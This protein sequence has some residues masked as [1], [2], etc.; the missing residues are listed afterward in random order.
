MLIA[1]PCVMG[2]GHVR[3]LLCLDQRVCRC[4]SHPQQTDWCYLRPAHHSLLVE[5]M[6][7]P[8][9]QE[10]VAVAACSYCQYGAQLCN[11]T[12]H[13]FRTVYT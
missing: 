13:V 9:T 5:D 1:A 6:A 7:C 11:K 2:A 10:H 12:L 8:I 4:V 3:Q